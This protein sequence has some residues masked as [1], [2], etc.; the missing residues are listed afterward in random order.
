MS[1]SRMPCSPGLLGQD[2]STKACIRE[3][4][5]LQDQPAHI[6]EHFLTL[7]NAGSS[8]EFANLPPE[9]PV[10]FLYMEVKFH[11]LL[12]PDEQC[13]LPGGQGPA[14]HPPRD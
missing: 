1:S 10:A 8:Q 6:R 7:A 14:V 2:Q 11:P 9:Y 4:A 3:W 12:E 5:D 13:S